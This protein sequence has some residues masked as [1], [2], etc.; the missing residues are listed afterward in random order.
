M[1]KVVQ[2][3]FPTAVKTAQIQNFGSEKSKLYIVLEKIY[4]YFS[5]KADIIVM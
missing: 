1:V 5:E 3:Y 4:L 2:M